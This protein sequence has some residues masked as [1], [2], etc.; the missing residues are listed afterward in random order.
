[1][2]LSIANKGGVLDRLYV[3]LYNYVKLI[4]IGGERMSKSNKEL[5]TELTIAF[6]N[7]WYKQSRV[8]SIQ[9][10]DVIDKIFNLFLKNLEQV[11]KNQEKSDAEE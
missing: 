6:L 1:M 10:Q 7:N 8:E 9:P 5:A 3:L 11:D 2:F 4:W